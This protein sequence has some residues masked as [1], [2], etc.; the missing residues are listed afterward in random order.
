MTT[1][2]GLGDVFPVFPQHNVTDGCVG[3]TKLRRQARLCR[4][5]GTVSG[6]NISHRCFGKFSAPELFAP[7]PRFRVQSRAVSVSTRCGCRVHTEP[8]PFA[9]GMSV[10][11]NHVN[12]IVLQ[13]AQK[14]VVRVAA[15]P[16]VAAV[17]NHETGSDGAVN[18][19]PHH[20]R[21]L[22]TLAVV[23]ELAIPL[24]EAPRC[25]RP[26]SVRPSRSVNLRPEPNFKRGA[27]S[28]LIVRHTTMGAVTTSA[29]ADI[30][31]VTEK[32]FAALSAGT[33]IRHLDPQCRGALPGAVSAATGLLST[34]ILSILPSDY[35]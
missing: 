20:A 11:G 23:V 4:Q 1:S 25:P 28:D 2:K 21:R 9:E 22:L 15:N 19:L 27:R 16:I 10:L 6:T 3:N 17:A 32:C 26:T 7:R 33:L 8:R 24:G 14:Q 12:D 30:R 13:G 18:Y 35:L 31:R 34:Q 29:L 5:L